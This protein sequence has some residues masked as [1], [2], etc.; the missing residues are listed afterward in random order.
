MG[1]EIAEETDYHLGTANASGVFHKLTPEATKQ[2]LRTIE[3]NIRF[4][5]HFYFR[6]ALDP[7]GR[8]RVA[9]LSG[10]PERM[11]ISGENAARSETF[12]VQLLLLDADDSPMQSARRTAGGFACQIV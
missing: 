3:Q 10:F 11:H 7:S 5:L 6:Q 2:Y 9:A 12:Y 8:R 1:W 4:A